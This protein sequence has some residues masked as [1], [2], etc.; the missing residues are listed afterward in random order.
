MCEI[1]ANAK[2]TR[3]INPLSTV[4]IYCIYTCMHYANWEYA[5]ILI[6]DDDVSIGEQNTR[7]SS[8]LALAY[9]YVYFMDEEKL[10]FREIF[11]CT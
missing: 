8:F 7:F 2:L 3:I 6:H 5:L 11:I 1:H 4:R 9:E 10:F